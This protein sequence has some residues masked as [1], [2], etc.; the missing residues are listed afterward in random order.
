M[1]ASRANEQPP[2]L[3]RKKATL[4]LACRVQDPE[5]LLH[6][7]LNAMPFAR[8]RQ[9]KSRHPFV[10]AALELINEVDELNTSAA[11]WADYRWNKERQASSSRV[12]AFILNASTSPLRMHFP[13]S[14]WVR[15]NYLRIGV[16]LFHSNLQKWELIS[17]AACEARRSRP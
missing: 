13:R 3:H 4:L 16:G 6:E 15:L 14:A 2:E 9:L 7:R 11:H 10:P 12:H 5:H 1:S 8:Y 17:S